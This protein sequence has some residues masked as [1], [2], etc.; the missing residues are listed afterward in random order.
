MAV[1]GKQREG[2]GGAEPA[3][4]SSDM[5]A[6]VRAFK[7]KMCLWENQML[8]AHFGPAAVA[9][10]VSRNLDLNR[11]PSQLTELQCDEWLKF[12]AVGAAQTR[13]LSSAL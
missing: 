4:S 1:S 2:N 9:T 7:T 12:D 13:G 6:S 11:F 10:L 3:A 8:P 5:Y